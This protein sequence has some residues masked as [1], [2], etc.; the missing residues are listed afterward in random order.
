[1]A[2]EW[3][4]QSPEAVDRAQQKDAEG[5]RHCSQGNR[6][7]RASIWPRAPKK[8]NFLELHLT[9]ILCADSELEASGKWNLR[10]LGTKNKGSEITLTLVW[11][12]LWQEQYGTQGETESERQK[13]KSGVKHDR[14]NC[15][16]WGKQLGN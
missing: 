2:R 7:L 11:A 1:M 3:P 4:V 8:C 14:F 16:F 5:G 13:R 6:L 12:A 10:M 9:K 15:L